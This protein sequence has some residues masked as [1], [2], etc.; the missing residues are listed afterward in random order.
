MLV[1]IE[2]EF[3]LSDKRNTISSLMNYTSIGQIQS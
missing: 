3:N 2:I 1:E